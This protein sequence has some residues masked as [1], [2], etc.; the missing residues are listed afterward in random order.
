MTEFREIFDFNLSSFTTYWDT[1]LAKGSLSGS[2]IAAER[3]KNKPAYTSALSWILWLVF[4]LGVTRSK[5]NKYAPFVRFFSDM[6][7]SS[8]CTINEYIQVSL[9]CYVLH[10]SLTKWRSA[11]VSCS[12]LCSWVLRISWIL[13]SDFWPRQTMS[14]EGT[15]EEDMVARSKPVLGDR[16]NH[17]RAFRIPRRMKLKDRLKSFPRALLSKLTMF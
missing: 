7:P 6:I 14:T 4:V 5:W 8:A 2:A 13:I 3:C 17:I 16:C 1:M 10:H 9:F 15:E 11:Y 12:K